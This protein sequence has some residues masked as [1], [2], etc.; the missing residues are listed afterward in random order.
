MS[1]K[2]VTLGLTSGFN[3]AECV[4]KGGYGVNEAMEYLK[5]LENT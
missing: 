1:V 2:A 5:E 3:I 4:S